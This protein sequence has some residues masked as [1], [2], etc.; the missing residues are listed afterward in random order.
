MAALASPT[1]PTLCPSALSIANETL[2][3]G[4]ESMLL[5]DFRVALRTLARSPGYTLV[6]LSTLVL[7][8][9]ANSSVFSIVNGVLFAPLGFPQEERLVRMREVSISGRLMST[10]WRN[11]AD[12]QT[13]S[14]HFESMAAYLPSEATVLGTG[15][16]LRR[17]VAR[18]SAEFFT[19][20][21][22]QPVFGRAPTTADHR[23]G[24]EAVAVVSTAF[25][26]SYLGGARDLASTRLT[27]GGH[28]LRVVAVM[29]AGFAY[30]DRTDIWY[31]LE[32]NAENDSR[33]S[34]NFEVVG[35]LK[36]GSTLV[37]AD[38]ELDA[39]TGRFAADDP[40]AARYAE[41]FPAS[42]EVRSLRE[43]LVG[44]LRRPLWVLLGAGFMVLL[45]ACTN[46]ASATLARGTTREHEYAVR[47]ALGAGRTQMV[48]VLVMETIALSA[49]GTLLGL[50]L[51]VVAIAALPF[52]AGDSIPQLHAVRVDARVI[53]F[54]IALSL[55]AAMV[56]GL[57]PGLRVSRSAARTLRSGGRAGHE[58]GRHR[59]WK[60]LIATEC[61]LVVLLLVGAGLLLRSFWTMLQV[62]PGFATTG[63]LT[64]TLNPP[65][66]KYAAKEAKRLYFTSLLDHLE[67][68]PGVASVGLTSAAPMSRIANGILEVAAGTQP[69]MSADYQLVSGGYFRTLGIPVL[70]GRTFDQRD[71]ET[72]EPVALVN[73][74]FA[75]QA[76]PG[77]DPI[78]RRITGGGMEDVRTW[79][80][81]IGV[82]ENIRQKDLADLGRPTAY[83]SYRQRPYRA[84]SMTAI[85]RPSRGDAVQLVSVVRNAVRA[86]DA[87]VPVSFSTIDERVALSLAPRRFL[88]S[89]LVIFGAIALLLASIG[90]YGVVAYAVER[91][92]KEIGVRFALGAQP[93]LIR[94]MIQR[95][96]M[97]PTALGALVGMLLTFALTRVLNSLLFEVKPTDPLTFAAVLAIVALVGWLASL[98]PAL[99]STRVDPLET[100]RSP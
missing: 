33:T 80:T 10:A 65:T 95:E 43:A 93:A 62:Q 100:M 99:R 3:P 76:W 20:L 89:V 22:A 91:R 14:T 5:Q 32:L 13:Q 28:T 88:L 69:T 56:S 2:Q 57:L 84:W 40:D 15:E 16:A 82:V 52:A 59:I 94:R 45:V 53:S 71:S 25:W 90:V 8:I 26:R 7:G 46:L 96:Y 35:R 60:G 78:G 81:V 85:L 9:G 55:A 72:G 37:Q 29:P 24:V 21:R 86:I 74:A 42:V 58:A 34:H 47:H 18:V 12:W 6:A 48:S 51:A 66:S 19:T 92:R 17:Q 31:P 97:V 49:L 98:I 54:T 87:D 70:R 41:Y 79:A 67:Q 68:L 73:R 4:Q 83:F 36:P 38:A 11:F 1:K 44:N 23:M 63:V 61:A 30:P 77:L 27:I 39:I 64:A 50:M 75:D